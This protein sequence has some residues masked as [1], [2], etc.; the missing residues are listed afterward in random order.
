M[1]YKFELSEEAI[2]IFEKWVEEQV[3]KSKV[4]HEFGDRFSIQ[5]TP[6][7]MGT[8][9]TAIDNHLEEEILLTDLKN[10]L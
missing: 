2:K 10:L 9:A 5:F 4:F 6:T 1:E 3:E 7:I 8:I